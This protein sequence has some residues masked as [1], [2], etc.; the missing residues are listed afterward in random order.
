MLFKV[1]TLAT[2]LDLS[3][4]YTKPTLLHMNDHPSH[5]TEGRAG[6]INIYIYGEDIPAE[7]IDNNGGTTYVRAYYGDFP[8]V[9][10]ATNDLK[11]KAEILRGDDLKLHAG[12]AI[13]STFQP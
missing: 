3:K 2:L 11:A 5:L 1:L 13:T 10:T 4:A 8:R 9:I 6:Y 12:D 7:V